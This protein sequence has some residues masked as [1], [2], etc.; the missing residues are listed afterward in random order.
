MHGACQECSPLHEIIYDDLTSTRLLKGSMLQSISQHSPAA[1]SPPTREQ[2]LYLSIQQ[3]PAAASPPRQQ[4]LYLSIQQQQHLHPGS[5][6]YIS[7]FS[8]SS[9]STQ[10]AKSI[11]QHSAFTSSSI[12]TQAEKS[13]SQHSPAAASPPRQQSLYLSIQ[14]SPAAASPPRQQIHVDSAGPF[15]RKMY[16]YLT[17]WP[18]QLHRTP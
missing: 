6:V 10:A 16:M 13:I 8:S 12:S 9:I 1:A 14:H 4:S 17:I 2:S 15:Q 18:L 3:S 11:S 7:A 5:K